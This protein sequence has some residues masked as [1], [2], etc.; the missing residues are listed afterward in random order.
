MT[1]SEINANL[2]RRLDDITVQLDRIQEMDGD[3]SVSDHRRALRDVTRAIEQI[4]QRMKGRT[5]IAPAAHGLRSIMP[6]A[7]K[8]SRLLLM[9]AWSRL[10]RNRRNWKDSR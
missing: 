2:R 4:V 5:T 1:E 8:T 9:R 10:S 6:D 3:Y 7:F